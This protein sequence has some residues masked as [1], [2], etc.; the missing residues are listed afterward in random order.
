MR[1]IR[2]HV[3]VLLLVL[4]LVLLAVSA[5]AMNTIGPAERPLTL[6]APADEQCPA[7]LHHA[8]PPLLDRTAS[9]PYVSRL[10]IEEKDDLATLNFSGDFLSPY[11]GASLRPA[12]SSI[13]DPALPP[14]LGLRLGAG[15]D[16]QLDPLTRLVFNYSFHL[17]TD[18]TSE[19]KPRPEENYTIS[20]G[21]QFAF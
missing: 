1:N 13:D 3:G 15:F 21:L 12:N 11:I 7:E 2:I 20:L 19:S 6:G 4:A 18:S 14:T 10:R 16:C 8:I 9:P 5:A 17:L